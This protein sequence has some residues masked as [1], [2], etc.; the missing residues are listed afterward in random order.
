MITK[1]TLDGTLPIANIM[2]EKNELLRNYNPARVDDS[3]EIAPVQ[4]TPK[5]ME[6]NVKVKRQEQHNQKLQSGKR[7]EL[8]TFQHEK[9]DDNNSCTNDPTWEA[10]AILK[11]TVVD[12]KELKVFGLK[13]GGR[14]QN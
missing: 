7:L 5:Q 13:V 2:A 12:L 4:Y 8:E 3:D 6:M 1:E 9:T 11:K 10:E 14:K